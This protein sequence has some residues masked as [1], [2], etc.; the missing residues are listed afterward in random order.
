MKTGHIQLGQRKD[1]INI[2]SQSICNAS[3]DLIFVSNNI[4][5]RNGGKYLKSME[6]TRVF[7]NRTAVKQTRAPKS[8]EHGLKSISE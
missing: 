1:Q 3:K 8:T 6:E 5:G 2:S 7:L 4:I